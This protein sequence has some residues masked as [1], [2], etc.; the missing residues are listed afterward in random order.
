MHTDISF[1]ASFVWVGNRAVCSARLLDAV[2]PD[3]V[4]YP[5]HHNNNNNNNNN[6]I[7]A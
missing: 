5:I 1:G 7:V 3:H 2:L 4:I 6:K